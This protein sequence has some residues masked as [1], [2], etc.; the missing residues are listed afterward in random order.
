MFFQEIWRKH[1]LVAM[2]TKREIIGQY[3]GSGLG[4]VW[5]IIHPVIM[6]TVYWFVF[7]VGFK[8]KPTNDVPFVI[9]LTAGL[10]PWFFFSS[11]VSGATTVVV[12]H[13]HLIKKTI[14][15]PQILPLVKVCASLMTHFI[16]LII[17]LILIIFQH[18]PLL[19]WCLQLVYYLVCLG[20]LALGLSWLFSTLY[21]FVR[22]VNQMVSVAL[23]IGF[24]VTPIFWDIKMMPMKIQKL[25]KLNPVFYIIQGYRDSLITGTP[26]WHR[27]LYTLY[28]W[29]CALLLLCLGVLV[30]TRLKPQF[31]DVL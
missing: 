19:I 16:F 24:W 14:F 12:E 4:P 31:S 20:V 1:R 3:V 8:V 5:M 23:Q 28:F 22:D 26:F 2:M 25:L 9:W 11:I 17:L 27:P 7:S 30:F 18:M 13:A 15:S 21:V 29:G 10:A 6:I